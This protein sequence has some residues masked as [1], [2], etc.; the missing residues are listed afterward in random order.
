MRELRF[1][2]AAALLLATAGR[3]QTAAPGSAQTSTRK[4]VTADPAYELDP[5]PGGAFQIITTGSDVT[6]ATNEKPRNSLFSLFDTR[7]SADDGAAMTIDVIQTSHTGIFTRTGLH[8]KSFTEPDNGGESSCILGVT[9]GGGNAAT[10]YKF[11]QLR[12]SGFTDYSDSPGPAV[13]IGTSAKGNAL[14]VISGAAVSGNTDHSDAIDI[15]IDNAASGGIVVEPGD[16]DFDDRYA[17][18]VGNHQSDD[19]PA[20]ITSWWQLNGLTSFTG[21][22]LRNTANDGTAAALRFYKSRAGGSVATNEILGDLDWRFVNSHPEDVSGAIQRFTAADKTDGSE[23]VDY[24]IWLVA[25]GSLAERLHLSSSGNLSAT[26]K[27]SFGTATAG[28]GVTAL[29]SEANNTPGAADTAAV[30]VV[31]TNTGLAGR[32]SEY[33]F[34]ISAT[35]KFASLSGILQNADVNTTGDI[36]FNVRHNPSDS[37]LSNV[38]RITQA[39]HVVATATT[40]AVSCTNLGTG[41]SATIAGSDISFVVTMNTGTATGLSPSGACTITF[42]VP[43]DTA[44]PIV[45]MLV[46][47]AADW[48]ASATIRETT[49]SA[50]APVLTWSNGSTI[51][52]STSYKFNCIVVGR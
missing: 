52:A 32:I 2:V 36:G 44:P 14:L 46:K 50:T 26:G 7:T 6:S 42:Y 1:A 40:P 9:T 45:C 4:V 39:G 33:Q 30:R 28:A 22:T 19:V 49:E 24:G 25:G 31:N 18:V 47:G 35:S 17:Y 34:G 11:P 21:S 13:E 8:C 51:T 10:F 38:V 27:A 29:G 16:L 41:G 48:A 3:G 20:N 15:R 43:Y 23:D 5:E 37:T 12:P